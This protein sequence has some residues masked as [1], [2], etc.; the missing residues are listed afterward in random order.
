[1]EGLTLVGSPRE[2]A[3]TG[4][5]IT[6]L[7]DD[8]ATE[9]VLGEIL[10][11]LPEGGLHIA[12]STL[13]VPYSRALEERHKAA[14]RRYL[15]APVF[16]R[17]EAAA[18][19]ALRIVVAGEARDVE[20]TRPILSALGQEVHVVGERPYQAHA[21]K[22]GGNF[23]IAAMLEALSEAYVLVEKNGVK[24]EAFYEVVRAFFRSPVYENY[25]RILLERRF[26]PPGFALRLG[27]KDVRLIH[28]AAD[29]S[30]TPMPLAHLLLD[31]ML[32]GVARGMG[33][34]GY[35]LILNS[36]DPSEEGW[37]R[38]FELMVVGPLRLLRLLVP[39]FR[40]SGGGRVVALGPRVPL[41]YRATRLPPR[42]TASTRRSSP[43][44][45]RSARLPGA[46]SPRS[47]RPR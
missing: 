33:E 10:E 22:L 40:R 31:R 34:E 21:V 44:T 3:G 27:L 12:M 15:A 24:R 2:A 36:R 23:L 41:A 29:T 37:R 5:V 45:T 30:H 47:S 4:L 42:Y 11:G 19:R 38:H 13:G 7:A 18:S 16:G 25:G 26:T 46:I 32:E 1:V 9:A 43:S 28:Q 35:S 39:L 6:M 8:A 17:P 14:G 20:E